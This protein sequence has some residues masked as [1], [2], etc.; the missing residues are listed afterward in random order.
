M[1]YQHEEAFAIPVR[2]D[3]LIL[4]SDLSRFTEVPQS[5]SQALLSQALGCQALLS[6]VLGWVLHAE[7]RCGCYMLH[8]VAM[9]N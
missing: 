4:P 9:L 5:L 2:P 6:Q 7:M 1:D 3:V 8:W